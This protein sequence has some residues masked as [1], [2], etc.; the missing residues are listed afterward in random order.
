MLGS[1]GAELLKLSR[2]TSTWVLAAVWLLFPVVFLYLLPFVVV[3]VALEQPGAP[4]GGIE[5]AAGFLLPENFVAYVIRFMFSSFG[6]AVALLLGALA[7]GSEYGW[8]TVKMI[9]SQRPSRPAVLSAKLLALATTLLALTVAAL[10]IGAVCSLAVALIAG[11]PAD[12]PPLAR[13]PQGLGAGFLLL[14]VWAALGFA[15]AVSFKGSALAIG[16]G[17]IYAFAIEPTINLIVLFNEDLQTVAKLPPGQN[18][19]AL[20]NAFSG[21]EVPAGAT[22]PVF[23]DPPYAALALALYTAAFLALA[24][25]AFLRRDVT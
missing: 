18:A 3:T 5:T 25:L 13:L 23:F 4:P 2:R 17:L 14:A 1:Y 6:T 9:L 12:P 8:G 11:A 16:L 20:V 22:P 7:V 24:Y 21:T 10:A 19:A 15:L